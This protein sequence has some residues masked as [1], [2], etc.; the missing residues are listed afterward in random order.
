MKALNPAG[1]GCSLQ[2]STRLGC[3]PLQVPPRKMKNI[4]PWGKDGG[5]V[6]VTMFFIFAE[7]IERRWWA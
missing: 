6:S 1:I 4:L 5:I 2:V 3:T 7:V